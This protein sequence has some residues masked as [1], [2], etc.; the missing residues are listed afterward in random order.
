MA[1]QEARLGSFNNV[2]F[3]IVYYT[4]VGN[5]LGDSMHFT[6]YEATNAVSWGRSRLLTATKLEL[7]LVPERLKV[8]DQDVRLTKP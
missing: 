7:K 6:A 3:P 8:F 1:A 2:L 4:G 5:A